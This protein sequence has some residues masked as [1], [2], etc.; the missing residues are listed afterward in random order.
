MAKRSPTLVEEITSRPSVR[1]YALLTAAALL[2]VAV[3]LVEAEAGWW[4][5][6]AVA[7]GLG[8]LLARWVVAPPLILFGTTLVLLMPS[9]RGMMMAHQPGRETMLGVLLAL[10][11]LVYLAAHLRLL[12]LVSHA[13]PPDRRR[14]E[15]ESPRLA[16]RWLL[17]DAVT[18]RT[19]APPV[20]GEM[21]TL[22]L[23]A[24][25]FAAVAYLLWVRLALERPPEDIGLPVVV[26]RGLMVVWT[27]GLLLLL[28]N[29]FLAYLRRSLA[30]PDASL[31]YLQDQLWQATRGEGRRLWRWFTWARLRREK[32]EERR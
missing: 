32:K 4:A 6:A 22:L 21:A 20:V 17:S 23:A 13:I 3:L 12:T 5:L 11:L 1:D 25:A 19:V 28:A 26:W 10:A 15:P 16:R 29:V 24:A 30:R 31:L 2:V 8:G 7:I 27:L 9:Q 18:R 14:L